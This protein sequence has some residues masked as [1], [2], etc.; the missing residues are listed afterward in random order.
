[1]GR[2]RGWFFC[3]KKVSWTRID[4]LEKEGGVTYR[5]DATYNSPGD[6]TEEH[7]SGRVMFIDENCREGHKQK[8][9]KARRRKWEKRYRSHKR[10][11]EETQTGLVGQLVRERKKKN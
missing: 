6:D 9:G 8:G 10:P 1:V 2:H 4:R 11:R 7:V 5:M 3:V